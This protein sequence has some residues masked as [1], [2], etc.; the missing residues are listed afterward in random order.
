VATVTVSEERLPD[1][2]RQRQLVVEAP[3]CDAERRSD[4]L[5]D[6]RRGL[7]GRDQAGQVQ[8]RQVPGLGRAL[9]AAGRATARL[10]LPWLFEDFETEKGVPP[11]VHPNPHDAADLDRAVGGPASFI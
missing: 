7:I 8:R 4:R 3:D 1:V 6:R 9:P 5:A 10:Q 2:G 11:R